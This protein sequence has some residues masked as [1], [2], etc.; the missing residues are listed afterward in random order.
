MWLKLCFLLLYFTLLFV[1]ARV[2]EVVWYERG[3]F[4][5]QLVDPVGLSLERLRSVLELRGLGPRGLGPDLE[6]RGPDLEDRR[7]VSRL[8]RESGRSRAGAGRNQH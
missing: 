7:G 4:T 6:D 2:L 5:A 3:A 1:L 8:V